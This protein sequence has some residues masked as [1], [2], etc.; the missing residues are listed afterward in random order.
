MKEHVLARQG[1][2]R[3]RAEEP[4]VAIAQ[5]AAVAVGGLNSTARREQGSDQAKDYTSFLEMY[6]VMVVSVTSRASIFITNAQ[7]ASRGD[8]V[9]HRERVAWF[10][11][12]ESDLF[13]E[14]TS[15][16]SECWCNREW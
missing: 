8:A 16:E 3:G 13:R 12:G 10:T 7:G 4:I 15:A 2:K 1:V 9:D 14:A 6:S 11:A 5:S